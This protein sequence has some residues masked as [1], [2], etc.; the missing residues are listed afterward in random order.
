MTS[1][2]VKN[3]TFL[4]HLSP[5]VGD[6]IFC[7]ECYIFSSFT[8]CSGW[9]H[10]PWS[11][12]HFWFIYFLRWMT[13]SSVKYATFLVHLPPEVGDIIFCEKCDCSSWPAC[14]PCSAWKSPTVVT[15]SAASKCRNQ[16]LM[17]TVN[18]NLPMHFSFGKQSKCDC[19]CHANLGLH[20]CDA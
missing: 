11:M 14:S 4:V 18:E 17:L 20:Y 2:T 7:E 19:K 10:L 15:G 8:T 3:A 1:S 6:I 9:H 5:E 16:H 13:S 12:L